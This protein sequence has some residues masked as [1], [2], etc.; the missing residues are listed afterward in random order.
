MNSTIIN[1]KTD[2][3][4]KKEAQKIVAGLSEI[5]NG[6]LKQLIRNKAIM[7]SLNEDTPSDYL[8]S[9]IKISRDERKTGSF[10][11]FKNNQS[12]INFLDNK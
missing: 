6:F 10:Y 1:I 8:L 4:V 7:F 5:I 9:S 11:Y 2:V 3:K 12:A